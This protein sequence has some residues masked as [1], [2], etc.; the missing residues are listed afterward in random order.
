MSI[1]V[2]NEKRFES[3]IE[4]FF[5]SEEGGYTS[6]TEPFDP[7]DALYKET[8]FKFIESTQP[9]E[10][11]RFVNANAVNPQR[12]FIKSFEY[13]CENLGLLYVLRN[14]FKHRGIQ[15]KVCYFKP[16]SDL[17]ETDNELY[18]KNIITC[19][20]QWHYSSTCKKSV[21]MVIAVNGI[22]VFA[23]ELKN[24]YTGQNVEDAKRQ[25]MY[26][27]DPYERCFRFDS[28]VLGFF[29]VDHTDVFM[30][31]KL[32]GEKTV[33]CHLTRVQMGQVMMVE[34][35]TQRTHTDIRRRIYGRRFFK[36]IA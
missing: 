9:K 12:A 19:N 34:Q 36:R 29:C 17:N 7:A 8:L 18:N 6:N 13:N 30:T 11:A 3:D 14:G 22:P 28:R 15:F 27:R 23:F 20:R 31:T 26:D 16:E 25:W 24:Q 35:E 33:F 21:D 10:W 2:T 1:D 5:L 4:A 32:D